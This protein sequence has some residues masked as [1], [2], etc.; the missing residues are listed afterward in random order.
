M[1]NDQTYKYDSETLLTEVAS[2][3]IIKTNNDT[4]KQFY[5]SSTGLIFLQNWNNSKQT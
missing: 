3:H 1:K 4:S 2:E 5:M